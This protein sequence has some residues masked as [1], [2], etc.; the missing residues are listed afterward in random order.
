MNQSIKKIALIVSIGTL[1]SKL[2]GL[3]RQLLIAGVFGVGASYDAY[4]YAYILPGFFLV[5]LG[6]ANGPLHNSMVSVLTNRS[7]EESLNIIQSI[8]TIITSF[9]ILISV[10]I[11]LKADIITSI[12]APGLNPDTH[13]IAVIQLKIMS[14]IVLISGLTGISFGSLNAKKE[15]LI[16]SIAPLISS[17]T[18]IIFIIAFWLKEGQVID[19]AEKAILGGITL[20]IAT[21]IGALLQLLIQIPSLIK[22]G[23]FKLNLAWNWKNKGVQKVIKLIIPATL[24]SGMLQI[25]VFTDL[26]FASNIIGAAASL[27]Y[28]NF[29]IQAPLGLISNAIIIPLLPTLAT[30]YSQKNIVELNKIIKKGLTLSTTSMVFIGSIFISLSSPIVE[31]FYSRGAFN[32]SA[33]SVVSQLLIAYGI[34]MPFYL[35]RDFLVRVFYSIGDA[36]TPFKISFIGIGLNIFLDWI[37]VGSP[38]PYGQIFAINLGVQGLVF[39]TVIVNLITCIFLLFKLNLILDD[40]NLGKLAVYLIRLSITGITSGIVSWRLSLLISWAND[41]PILLANVMIII[42]SFTLIFCFLGS[43]LG[44]KEL[45]TITKIFKRKIYSSFK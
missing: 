22:K 42:L 20:A 6:G 26:F 27:G 19:S 30:S 7:K 1:A 29:I 17:I 39:A 15:F 12:L 9:L 23:I 14:P 11:L 25:N 13:K 34:G 8:Q 40:M 3:I 36:Q 10:F 45:K 38:S 33:I 5:L 28:A 2:G 4:N 16:P 18:L 43:Q 44:L 41:F 24:S 32:N 31:L 35:G 21:T 37:L